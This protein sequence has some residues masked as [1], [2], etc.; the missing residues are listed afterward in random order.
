M[1]RQQDAGVSKAQ[2]SAGGGSKKQR[3][4]TSVDYSPHRP[5]MAKALFTTA[6]ASLN[7]KQSSD[8]KA[9]TKEAFAQSFE[10]D[11]SELDVEHLYVSTLQRMQRDGELG[12]RKARGA[13]KRASD[14]VVQRALDLFLRGNGEPEPKWLGFTSLKHALASSE[15]LAK[16]H[17]QSGVTEYTLWGRMKQRYQEEH[18]KELKKLCITFKPKLSAEVKQARLDAAKAWKKLKLENVVFLDEKQEYL[19]EGGTYRCYGPPEKKS[20]Q[21]ETDQALGKASKLKY[22]AAVSGFAGPLYLK[23]VTGTTNL[24][25]GYKVRT[26]PLRTDLHPTGR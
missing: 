18:G 5:L 1:H 15:K 8:F 17:E 19:R 4:R 3:T 22:L 6:L 12:N 2:G 13:E 7:K 20:F 24:K 21:R 25:K 23:A 14:A 11:I 10:G 9:K 26:V 16:I